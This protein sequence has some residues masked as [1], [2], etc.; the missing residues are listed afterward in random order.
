MGK[1]IYSLI[2]SF[3]GYINDADG[4]FQWGAPDTEVMTHLNACLRQQQTHL[5]GRK[6]YELMRYW[7]DDANLAQHSGADLE[8]ADVWNP[9]RKII[10]STTLKNVDTRNTSLERE[11]DPTVARKLLDTLDHDATISGANLGAQALRAGIVDEIHQY[12]IPIVLGGGQ[13]FLPDDVRLNLNLLD[14]Q[15]FA[16]GTVFLRYAINH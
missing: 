13:R 15:R 12:L 3:D 9:S 16:N 4:D 10:F 1:L 14:E 7:D 2:T 5:I 8:F 11:F 6:M